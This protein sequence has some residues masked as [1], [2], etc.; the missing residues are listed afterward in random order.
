MSE[1]DLNYAAAD[2]NV[3]NATEAAT[4]RHGSLGSNGISAKA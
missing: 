2:P 4:G 3:Y 1:A